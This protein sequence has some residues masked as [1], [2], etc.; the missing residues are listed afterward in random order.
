ML[1]A[2]GAE[3]LDALAGL[4]EKV[5]RGRIGDAEVRA[6]AESRSLHDGDAFGFQKFGNEIRIRLDD[7]ARRR[8]LADQAG[9]GRINVECAFRSRAADALGTV[10]HGDDEVTAAFEDFLV[11]RN[12]I[13]RA[14]QSFDSG[15]LRNRACARGLL[16]LDHVHGLDQRQR[17]GS[18]TDTPAGHGIGLE[19]PFI[20]SVRS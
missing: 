6:E 10:E 17:A 5:F 7:L 18:V 19:T 1:R 9:A 3:A 11:R 12:E 4:F 14:V 20:V 8:G 16:A 15:P 2:I 13:L